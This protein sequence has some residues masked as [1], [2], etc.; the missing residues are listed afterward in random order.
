MLHLITEIG[1]P[2]RTEREKKHFPDLHNVPGER[3]R[4]IPRGRV[5]IPHGTSSKD[6]TDWQPHAQML[7]PRY[8]EAGPDWNSKLRYLEPNHSD[9]YPAEPI[10]PEN[11]KSLRPNAERWRTGRDE[12]VFYDNGYNRGR[13]CIINNEHKSSN[14]SNREITHT[15]LFG[16]NRKFPNVMTKRGAIWRAAPGDKSYQVSEYSPSFHKIG[17]TRPVVN[18][19]GEP[20][21]KPDTFVP[22]QNISYGRRETFSQ[23][24]KRERYEN[25]IT[26][27]RD[28][29]H[30]QPA[31]PLSETVTK[32]EKEK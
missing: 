5:Y 29:D 23:K 20:S 26:R 24:E 13:R 21:D 3:P 7:Q 17:S 4:Q 25:E 18:F 16:C 19:G 10:F 8:T 14:E 28:L 22:L 12:W 32:V 1:K 6:D 11:W 30:W 31:T 2:G 27:V 9:D 15:E